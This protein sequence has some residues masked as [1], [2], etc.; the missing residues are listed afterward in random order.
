MIL[1]ENI[2]YEL[3]PSVLRRFLWVFELLTG[4]L[5]DLL[6]SEGEVKSGGNNSSGEGEGVSE[7]NLQFQTLFS[8]E[9]VLTRSKFHLIH[10]IFL[11]ARTGTKVRSR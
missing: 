10:L 4:S 1:I 7:A 11:L 3:Y 8:D 6:R 2:L 5:A 9:K